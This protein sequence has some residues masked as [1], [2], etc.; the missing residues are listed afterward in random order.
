MA[1]LDYGPSRPTSAEDKPFSEFRTPAHLTKYAKKIRSD[2]ER[3]FRLYSGKEVRLFQLDTESAR[4]SECTDSFTGAVL[5]NNCPICN[6]TGHTAQHIPVGDFWALAEIGPGVHLSSAM[7]NSENTRTGTDRLILVG[8]PLLTDRDLIAFIDTKSVYKVVDSDPA[9][10]ALNG[11]VVTQV[12]DVS[13][14]TPGSNEYK[15]IDW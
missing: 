15:V 7:G 4:C 9:V 5:N 6:G 11:D 1:P 13:Y 14:L 3:I 10:V 2:L 8:A 12:C